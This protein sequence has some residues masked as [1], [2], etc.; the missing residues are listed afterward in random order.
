METHEKENSDDN[1]IFNVSSVSLPL[2]FACLIHPT[3]VQKLHLNDS[4]L[5]IV[6]GEKNSIIL[7]KVIPDQTCP[8]DEIRIPESL[9]ISLQIKEGSQLPVVPYNALEYCTA[10]QVEPQF[11]TFGKNYFKEINEYLS[12]DSHPVSIGSYFIIYQND[13]KLIFKVTNCLPDDRCIASRATKIYQINPIPAVRYASSLSTHFSDISLEKSTFDQIKKF[14]YFPILH[15]KL[16]EAVNSITPNAVLISGQRGSGKTALLSAIAHSLDVPSLYINVER[17]LLLQLDS[18]LDTMKKC[19]T[20]PSGKSSSLLLFDGIDSLFSK[21]NKMPFRRVFSLFLGFL[22]HLLVQRNAIIVGTAHNIHSIDKSITRYG[23]FGFHIQLSGITQKQCEEIIALNTKGF[24]SFN[25][26]AE[27][28]SF[29]AECILNGQPTYDPKDQIKPP[30]EITPAD[31]KMKCKEA[32]EI[33]MKD[34][35]SKKTDFSIGA[36]L[37]SELKIEHFGFK[38]LPPPPEQEK[39]EEKVENNENSN[40]TTIEQTEKQTEV[41]TEKKEKIEVSRPEISNKEEIKEVN[42]NKEDKETIKNDDETLNIESNENTIE[43][44]IN[45]NQ[46][47]KNDN[48]NNEIDEPILEPKE[49]SVANPQETKKTKKKTKSEKKTET[50]TTVANEIPQ[51]ETKEEA[52]DDQ[53][54]EES[55]IPNEET[56]EVE[57]PQLANEQTEPIE[58]IQNEEEMMFEQNDEEETQIECNEEEDQLEQNDEEEAQI[59]Q[60]EEETKIE[61]HDEEETQFEENQEE[62]EHS[63][64]TQDNITENVEELDLEMSAIKEEKIVDTRIETEFGNSFFITPIAKEQPTM[65]SETTKP[66]EKERKPMDLLAI[67]ASLREEFKDDAYS[68]SDD[69]EPVNTQAKEIKS[70]PKPIKQPKNNSPFGKKSN[71][72]QPKQS[73]VS[74]E[75]PFGTIKHHRKIDSYSSSDSEDNNRQSSFT[76]PPPQKVAEPKPQ[77]KKALKDDTNDLI[78]ITISEPPKTNFDND[79][80]INDFISL[81]S[82]KKTEFPTTKTPQSSLPKRKKPAQP[83]T[84]SNNKHIQTAGHTDPFAIV[85]KPKTLNN[86]QRKKQKLAFEPSPGSDEED[87]Q[88]KTDLFGLLPANIQMNTK[89]KKEKRA[90]QNPSNTSFGDDLLDFCIPSTQNT[91]Q[92]SFNSTSNHSQPI[93]SINSNTSTQINNLTTNSFTQSIQPTNPV[94]NFNSQISSIQEKSKTS[95]NKTSKS[96]PIVSPIFVP[97]APMKG[98]VVRRSK[99]EDIEEETEQDSNQM[100]V[101]NQQ[102]SLF[103]LPKPS[104]NSAFTNNEEQENYYPTQH[105]HRDYK[106]SVN[107]PFSKHRKKKETDNQTN[108]DLQAQ[109]SIEA[110]FGSNEEMNKEDPFANIQLSGYGSNF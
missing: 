107:D 88:R 41:E 63:E 89:V 73:F 50:K 110:L 106:R 6:K 66:K 43:P 93:Q 3:R 80:F 22:D 30:K 37:N 78:D 60:N 20:F 39:T 105:H 101:F 95:E 108:Q 72:N 85:E 99:F 53:H 25:S 40:E 104:P 103:Q 79:D 14:I 46:G 31:V 55:N 98:V 1:M 11:E 51:K 16:F 35:G 15:K 56:T 68:Y 96:K 81:A 17:L 9:Q 42:D 92:S 61:Q 83:T 21:S 64:N 94:V 44:A 109:E 52:L 27:D 57:P 26:N 87:K 28:I 75:S 65:R 32:I 58:N 29:I 10:L 97:S 18:I 2:N 54:E 8:I 47:A 23:R 74:Q 13:Q 102:Q 33:L 19:F 48:E 4:S 34:R 90:S 7:I 77:K 67:A 12:T 84:V 24:N 91:N 59:E 100:N 71:T 38:R 86:P 82:Q 62:M 5:A 49:D 36:T 45:D 76:Q 70:K 69:D